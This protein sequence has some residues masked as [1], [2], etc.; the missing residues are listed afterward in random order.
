MTKGLIFDLDGVIVDTARFHYT[1]WREL[2][3]EW[4]YKLSYKENEQLKGVSRMD[5]IRKIAQWAGKDFEQDALVKMATAKNELYLNL[6]ESLSIQDVLPGV[7][8]ILHDSINKGLKLAVGSASKNATLV[9]KK[10]GII[11][12]F[13]VV[14]DG[15][16]VTHSKPHPEVFI[17]AAQSMGLQP[18]ECIVFEDAQAGIE[19]ARA[20]NMFAVG[21]SLDMLIGCDYQINNF[22]KITV[23]TLLEKAESLK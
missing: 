7:L 10:L 20:G 1:A 15:N 13:E 2:A 19:A 23:E 14:V 6:C 8:R 18:S 16:M 22:K 3:A 4:G 5:S 11:D 9:L 21:V 17:K 12:L